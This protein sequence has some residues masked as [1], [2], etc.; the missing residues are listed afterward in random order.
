M[1]VQMVD[2]VSWIGVLI[3]EAEAWR[4]STSACRNSDNKLS[5]RAAVR[6][7]ITTVQARRIEK[8]LLSLGPRVNQKEGHPTLL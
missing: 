1:M 7:D 3:H 6:L 4:S 8:P 2:T 5:D